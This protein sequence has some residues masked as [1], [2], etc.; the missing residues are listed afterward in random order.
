[1]TGVEPLGAEEIARLRGLGQGQVPD[2]VAQ[3]VASAPKVQ[4]LDLFEQY[5]VSGDLLLVTSD[6]SALRLEPGDFIVRRIWS[7]AAEPI[8]VNRA[9]GA[10]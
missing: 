10:S 1:M 5:E 9:G 4:G 2:V 8:E 7:T 6:A 3:I